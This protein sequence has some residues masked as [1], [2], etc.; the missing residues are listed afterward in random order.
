VGGKADYKE[1]LSCLKGSL[2]TSA[3]TLAMYGVANP[4]G[5]DL[6]ITKVIIDFTSPCSATPV[7]FDAGCAAATIT[8]SDDNL[9]DEVD[10][11]TP[12]AVAVYN[13][14]DDGGTNGALS[15]KWESDK[16]FTITAS[17]SPTGIAGSVYIYYRTV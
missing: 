10:I 3:S 11:G 6:I 7:T 15:R 16:Y 17:A 12:T 8:T 14:A 1:Q 5:T 13:S 9:M 4:L 2:S